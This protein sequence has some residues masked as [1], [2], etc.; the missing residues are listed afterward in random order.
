MSDQV[1][2]GVVG[3]GKIARDQHLPAIDAEPGFKLTACASRHAEVAGV[4]NYH[5]LRALLAAERELDAVSLCAPPQ[6]RYAQARAA[7]EAGKHV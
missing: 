5:D 3:I 2:L 7:F 4:R 1:S 6:V